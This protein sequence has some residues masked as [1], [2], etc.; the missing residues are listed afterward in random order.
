VTPPQPKLADGTLVVLDG[1]SDDVVVPPDEA[2]VPPD[3]VVAVDVPVVE[4]APEDGGA[5]AEVALSGEVAAEDSPPAHPATITEAAAAAAAAEIE[6]IVMAI[7]ASSD[8]DIQVKAYKNSKLRE[9]PCGRH[10]RCGWLNRKSV[11]YDRQRRK[12]R[13]GTGNAHS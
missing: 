8:R 3:E 1:V 13:R 10:S 9:Q 11:G 4:M 2:V 5:V 12:Q 7:A 6:R